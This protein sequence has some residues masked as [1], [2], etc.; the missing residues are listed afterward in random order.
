MRIRRKT[1]RIAMR[2]TLHNSQKNISKDV[3]VIT[4]NNLQTFINFE[5][6]FCILFTYLI[7]RNLR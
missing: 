5:I 1:R 7:I 3:K 6:F 4:N 2:N